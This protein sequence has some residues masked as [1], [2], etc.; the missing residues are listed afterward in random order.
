MAS[1]SIHASHPSFNAELLNV[2]PERAV[3]AFVACGDLSV[4]DQG[5]VWRHRRKVGGVWPKLIDVVP[6]VRAENI[7][8]TKRYQ[9]QVYVLGNRIVC[10]AAR[11]VWFLAYGEIPV[12]HH[13]H[14]RNE[15]YQD[16]NLFNLECLTE[17][18][19]ISA[20]AT[21]R[22]NELSDIYEQQRNETWRLWESGRTYNEI[23]EIFG[24][25]RI[26]VA[27]RLRR[28]REDHNIQGRNHKA[29]MR[30]VLKNNGVLQAS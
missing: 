17:F 2:S 25:T 18:A 10:H 5:R 9:I 21:D 12:N 29:N 13:I 23:A 8:T 14:H 6:A 4:D 26:G 3:A 27:E 16:N 20:H 30:K 15:D 1:I 19:H 7:I 24:L 28:Y 22:H 11:L